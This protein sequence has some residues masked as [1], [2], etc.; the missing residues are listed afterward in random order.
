MV[1]NTIGHLRG[2]AVGRFLAVF[3]GKSCDCEGGVREGLSVAGGD[4]SGERDGCECGE[5][6][7]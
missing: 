6:D 3:G 7:G 5:D 1:V 4:V 2:H